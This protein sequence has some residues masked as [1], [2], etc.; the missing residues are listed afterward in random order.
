MEA[1]VVRGIVFVLLWKPD[2]A[3]GDL[4]DE[5]RTASD[6]AT[7]TF[8]VVVRAKRASSAVVSLDK[9]PQKTLDDA[10]STCV[11]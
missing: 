9:G 1:C 8:R 7:N 4:A 10:E 6:D 11:I 3:E 5:L 2:F